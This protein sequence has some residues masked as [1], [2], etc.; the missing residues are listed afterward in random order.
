MTN[1]VP[2]ENI[3]EFHINTFI[4]GALILLYSL[5]LA[6]N[7]MLVMSESKALLLI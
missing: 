6:Y 1:D 5:H 2:L 3:A 7:I 4:F